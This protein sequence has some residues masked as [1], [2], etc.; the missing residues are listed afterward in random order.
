MRIQ[1]VLRTTQFYQAWNKIHHA[2]HEQRA[3]L[4]WSRQSEASLGSRETTTGFPD[5]RKR[6]EEKFTE[7]FTIIQTLQE[8]AF[9]QADLGV[10]N[11]R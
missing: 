11:Y 5:C 6:L 9:D 7:P 10:L 3:D 2:K 8:A 1:S 4:Q